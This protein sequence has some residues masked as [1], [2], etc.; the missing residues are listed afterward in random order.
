MFAF[1]IVY[2]YY[3]VYTYIIGGVGDKYEV[4]SALKTYSEVLFGFIIA[5]TAQRSN[6]NERFFK[7]QVSEQFDEALD[8]ILVYG[9]TS[10]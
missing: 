4:C 2:L 1:I 9:A 8:D 7:F 5:K 10:I 3:T 6:S